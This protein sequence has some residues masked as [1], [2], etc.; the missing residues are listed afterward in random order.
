MQLSFMTPPDC[1][2]ALACIQRAVQSSQT[3]EQRWGAM[4]HWPWSLTPALYKRLQGQ[5]N[6]QKDCALWLICIDC[7]TC[8]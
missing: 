1:S 7:G 8:L 2:A 6:P 5:L 3:K 4:L